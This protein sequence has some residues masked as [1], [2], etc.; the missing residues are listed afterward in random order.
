MKTKKRVKQ[1][2]KN[3]SQ[4]YGNFR[5][6][7]N[8]LPKLKSYFIFSLALFLIVSIFGFI[9]PIFFEEQIMKLIKELIMLTA[10]MNT[11]ELISF[12]IFNNMKSAFFAMIFGIFFGIVPI[13]VV[14]VN[15]YVLGFV[16]NKTVASE[17]ILVLWRLFPHGIFEIPAVLLATALGMKLGFFFFSY[18]GSNKTQEFWKLIKTSLKF[19][20]LIIIPLLVIA[21]IIEG[22]L[23]GLIG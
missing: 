22:L 7:L 17:S 15:A 23:I 14:V 16:A 3:Q 21:G 18:K 5:Q 4:V 9:F 1:Q 11:L 6:S 8:F 12:I 13:G 10:G 19:F 20:L 2:I